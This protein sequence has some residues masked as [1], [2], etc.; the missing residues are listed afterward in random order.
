[1]PSAVFLVAAAC[2][3]AAYAAALLLLHRRGGALLVVCMLAVAIQL[4]P[5][6]GP[7]VLSQDAYAYWDYGRLAARHDANPYSVPP[8]RF[9]NDPATRAMAPAWRTTRSVYG[10]VFTGVSAGLATTSGSGEVAAFEF[11]LAAAAGM[12]ALVALVTLVAPVPAFAAAFVGWNPLLAVDFAG[13]GHNDVWM[14][15]LVLRAL[16][17]AARRPRLSGTGWALAAG[18]K[19]VALALLPLNLLGTR[20]ARA[21]LAGFLVTAAAIATAACFAFGASW[22]TA[23]FPLAQRHAAWAVPSR[24]GAVGL[25]GWLALLPLAIAVPWLVRSARSGR[26]RLGLTSGLLLIGTPWLLPWYAVWAV[27]LAAIEEDLVAWVLALAVCAY[28]LPD[29]VPI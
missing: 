7:L 5:L 17:L 8:A 29:R 14:M 3:F 24:L 18:V 6:A 15:V 13:G 11:R 4:I 27:A 20:R 25:P 1:V 28:L 12:L 21:P 22:L 19:W 23:V 26:G 10:P 9:P 16:A 2:A